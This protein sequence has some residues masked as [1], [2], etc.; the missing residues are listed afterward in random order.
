MN[1]RPEGRQA[2]P[3]PTLAQTQKNNEK[4][5]CGFRPIIF[6]CFSL[7]DF[8]IKFMKYFQNPGPV[9]VI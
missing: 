2:L 4:C 7:I 6:F 9:E 3:T 5:F 8:Q 1:P